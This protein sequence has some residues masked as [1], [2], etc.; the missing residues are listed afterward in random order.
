MICTETSSR[1]TFGIYHITFISSGYRTQLGVLTYLSTSSETKSHNSLA[2]STPVGPPPHTTKLNRVLR[3]S[4]DVLGR[5][6]RS[7]LSITRRRI[8]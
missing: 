4:G 5:A 2:N 1:S 7:R 3:S 8:A 6:A